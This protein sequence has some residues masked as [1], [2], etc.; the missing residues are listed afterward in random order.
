MKKILVVHLQQVGDVLISTAICS[1]IKN[2]MPDAVVHYLVA[3]FTA[4]IVEGHKDIDQIIKYEKNQGLLYQFKFLKFIR[5]QKYDIVIDILCKPRS[6][7][8]T[9]FSGAKSRISFNRKGRS[10]FYNTLVPKP[11]TRREYVVDNRCALL[12]PLGIEKK[13]E[14]KIKIYLEDELVNKWK[15]ALRDAGVTEKDFLIA[16]GVN[17]RRAY[18][19]WPNENFIK[20]INHCIEK[21]D[22]KILFFYNKKEYDDC[23]KIR[24]QVSKPENVI[25]SLSTPT[26]R[27]L[28]ALLKNC[29]LFVGNDSGPRHIAQAVNVPTLAIYSPSASKW[30]WNV[31]GDDRFVSI[32]IQDATGMSDSAFEKMLK[33]VTDENVSDHLRKITSEFV[34]ENLEKMIRQLN[35]R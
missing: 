12:K 27:D 3:S 25:A 29:N 21:W 11:E 17:S 4:G 5:D 6:G 15:T 28:S 22:A 18:K 13:Y 14:G 35:L 2:C 19:V 34:I 33:E 26:I 31:Q 20:V 10:W 23:Q 8:M 1:H 24:N 16:F 32:D 7:L 9:F 30:N